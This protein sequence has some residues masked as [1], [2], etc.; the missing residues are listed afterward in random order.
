MFNENLMSSVKVKRDDLLVT[1]Y[2]NLGAHS[3]AVKEALEARRA[4]MLEYF[5][6]GIERLERDDK[7]QPKATI[8][9]P[10][11]KDNS[12]D[13]K[14][15]IRMVEMTVEEVIELTEAQFD[16][17]VMDNWNWKQELINTTSLYG[18]LK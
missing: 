14:R 10:I 15:A 7:Y 11:P 6:F 18:K 3:T 17:L 2:Q 1:L 4:E 5:Q 8:T 13:Y 12:S 9:F 16:K